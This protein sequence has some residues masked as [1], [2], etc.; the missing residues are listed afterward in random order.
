MPVNTK[1]NHCT[2]PSRETVLQKQQSKEVVFLCPKKYHC[3]NFKGLHI[4]GTPHL[5]LSLMQSNSTNFCLG[6]CRIRSVISLEGKKKKETI[7]KTSTNH[8]NSGSVRYSSMVIHFTLAVCVI[9]LRNTISCITFLNLSCGST[10][11][12]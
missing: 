11:M 10:H 9:F 3:L 4:G 6:L 8:Q 12:E 5:V 7:T 2:V 1:A